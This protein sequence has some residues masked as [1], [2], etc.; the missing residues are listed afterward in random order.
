MRNPEMFIQCY[1]NALFPK[2]GNIILE[3]VAIID[4]ETGTLLKYGNKDESLINY[5]NKC[6]QAG[7]PAKLIEFDQTLF[8]TDDICTILN[9][10]INCHG[11]ELLKF[12]SLKDKD[13][14]HKIITKWKTFGY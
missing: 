11:E 10:G 4:S 8:T 7:I 9:Y 5:L 2:Y 14:I 6:N 3:P 13:I 1:N 12:L